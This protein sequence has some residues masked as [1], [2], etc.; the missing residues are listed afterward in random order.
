MEEGAHGGTSFGSPV[1]LR[2]RALYPLSYG[3]WGR[4]VYP[5]SGITDLGAGADLGTPKG[6]G[7]AHETR[8]AAWRTEYEVREVVGDDPNATLAPRHRCFEYL[9]AVEFALDYLDEN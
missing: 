8:H 6:A 5:G 9:E 7:M 2:R 4:L 1:L 3:R